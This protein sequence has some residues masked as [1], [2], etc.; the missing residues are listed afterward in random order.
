LL[1][2]VCIDILV[3]HYKMYMGLSYRAMLVPFVAVWLRKLINE[4]SIKRG[5]DSFEGILM[6]C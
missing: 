3:N 2:D 1:R 4:F 6:K 5:N